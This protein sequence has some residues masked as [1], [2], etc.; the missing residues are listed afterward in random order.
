MRSVVR[1]RKVLG[2]NRKIEYVTGTE[3]LFVRCWMGKK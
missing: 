2:L 1:I 3:F